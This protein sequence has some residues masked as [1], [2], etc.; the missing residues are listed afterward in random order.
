MIGRSERVRLEPAGTQD[1]DDSCDSEN[2]D[3]DRDNDGRSIIEGSHEVADV[4]EESSAEASDIRPGIAESHSDEQSNAKADVAAGP[5]TSNDAVIDVHDC[6]IDHD[7]DSGE[8]AEDTQQ[9]CQ[10][11]DPCGYTVCFEGHVVSP[12]SVPRIGD[13]K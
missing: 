9:E 13:F 2:E 4:A 8:R 10:P 11:G 5:L 1:S 6:W 7:G 3:H 12:R